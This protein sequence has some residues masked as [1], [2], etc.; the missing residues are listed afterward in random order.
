MNFMGRSHLCK[1]ALNNTKQSGKLDIRYTYRIKT[2]TYLAQ[3]I[4]LVVL[5]DL[6]SSGQ[7][8]AGFLNE[9]HP[10]EATL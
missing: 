4:K 10:F 9:V 5:Q 1:I 2:H 7:L 3:T 8:Y 6:Y